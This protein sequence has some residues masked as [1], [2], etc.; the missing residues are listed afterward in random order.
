MDEVALWPLKARR[1]GR[2]IKIGRRSLG[3]AFLSYTREKHFPFLAVL[4]MWPPFSC[5]LNRAEQKGWQS[6]TRC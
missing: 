1:V 5:A 4:D 3:Y 2:N 6:R